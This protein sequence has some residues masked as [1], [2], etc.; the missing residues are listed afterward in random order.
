ML[1][2][3]ESLCAETRNWFTDE[4]VVS[5]YTIEGGGLSLPFLSI[6]QFFRIVGSK[7]NDGLYIY[8]PEGKVYHEVEWKEPYDAAKTWDS[9]PKVVWKETAG[10]ALA[11]ETFHGAIWPMSVPSAFIKLAEEVMEYNKSDISKPSVLV[12]ESFGGYSYTKNSNNTDA[13]WQNAFKSKLR[14][15][16]KVGNVC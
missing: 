3:I 10:F 6:G 11:D 4:P 14:R 16:R 7:F 13:T 15:W 5:D 9:V 2:T 1:S 8:G 12:S